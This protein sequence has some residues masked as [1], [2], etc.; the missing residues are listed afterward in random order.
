MSAILLLTDGTITVDLLNPTG[1]HLAANGLKLKVAKENPIGDGYE[2]VTEVIKLTWNQATDDERDTIAQNL[3]LLARKARE[4]IRKRKATGHV[5]MQMQTASSSKELYALVTD[6]QMSD[7]DSRHWDADQVVDLTL[8]VTREGA[9]RDVQP[10][11]FVPVMILGELITNQEDHALVNYVTVA[12][13]LAKGDALGI[14][15]IAMN[16]PS[17]SDVQTTIIIASKSGTEDELDNFTPN[18]YPASFDG[19]SNIVADAGIPGGQLYSLDA[20][21]VPVGAFFDY[22]NIPLPTDLAYYDGE[23][24][25]YMVAR[26]TMGTD[27]V[28]VTG[29]QTICPPGTAGTVL[30][31]TGDPVSLEASN[32]D[33]VMVYL[34]RASIPFMGF[35]P[36]LD[37]P[38]SDKYCLT[39]DIRVGELSKL[40]IAEVFIVPVHSIHGS[41]FMLTPYLNQGVT[42]HS[43]LERSFTYTSSGEYSE[44]NP[45]AMGRYPLVPPGMFTRFWFW[46][47][48]SDG[49]GGFTFT[50]EFTVQIGLVRRYLALRGNV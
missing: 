38:A 1:L 14:P 34:G 7:L 29:G 40:E 9:W 17:G 20:G 26:V 25:M 43:D 28:V 36:S 19:T 50:D 12:N 2:D 39:L 46:Y 44:Y 3:N 42:V 37:T 35:I 16:D 6:I 30:H 33:F 18:F 5:W 23:Y 13:T 15:F 41:P 48:H 10:N 4:F 11:D 21:P 47:Q 24:L 22:V 45:Y 32:T 31:A 49:G 27:P 8:F